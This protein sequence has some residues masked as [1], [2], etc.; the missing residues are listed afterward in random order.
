MLIYHT[1]NVLL[2]RQAYEKTLVSNSSIFAEQ[3]SSSEQLRQDISLELAY[4]WEDARSK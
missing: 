2:G 3:N 4:L 1:N